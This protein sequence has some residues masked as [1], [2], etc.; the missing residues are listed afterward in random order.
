MMKRTGLA[1][2]RALSFYYIM[3]SGTVAKRIT[4][5]PKRATNWEKMCVFFR[6]M[7]MYARGEYAKEC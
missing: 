6:Y 1:A 3:G 4:G 2:M 5:F 7:I